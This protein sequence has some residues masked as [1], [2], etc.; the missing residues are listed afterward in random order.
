M[1][2][3]TIDYSPGIR[4]FIPLLYV[5]WADGLLSP[6]EVKLIDQQINSLDELSQSEKEILR[7]WIDPADWPDSQ[8]FKIWVQLM[9]ESARESETEILKSIA[10]LGKVMAERAAIEGRSAWQGGKTYQA[11]KFL[12]EELGV[13]GV[14]KFRAIQPKPSDGTGKSAANA[15]AIQDWLDGPA[16]DVKGR[17]K[18]VLSD[19][20]FSYEE[21]L[22][23]EAY[24]DRALLWLKLLGEQGYGSLGFPQ[25][26]GGKDD[27]MEYAAVF[28]VL[29]YHDLSLAVKFGVQFGLFGGSIFNLGTKIHHEKYLQKIGTVELPGCFAMTETGHGSNVRDLETTGLYDPDKGEIEVHS[30]TYSA[31]KEYIGNALHGKMATVFLQLIVQGENHGVHA[32][33]VPIRNDSGDLLPGIRVE[34]NGRKLG[35]NG[36]DNGRIWFEHVRVPREN[37]LNRFGQ[38]T[39]L[40][41]YES[42]IPNPSK[43]FFTMLG[44][45]VAGRLCVAMG[46]L[47]A[48]KSA[49]T[50]AVRYALARRQFKP[51]NKSVETLIMDYP[52]HQRR[53]MP[54]LVEAIALHLALSDLIQVYSQKGRQNNRDIEAM[55][56]GLKARSTWFA[57]DAIQECREACG[58]KGYLWENRF[59]DLKADSDIFTTF[60]GDNTVLLQLVAKSLLSNF[61]E[62]F[63]DA[64][65][66]GIIRYL[67]TRVSDR[68][69]QLNPVYKRKTDA[70]HLRDPRFHLHAA[71]YRERKLLHTLGSRI[72]QMFR[73]RIT[74]YDVFLRTQNHMIILAQ[75]Y[76]DRL[77]LEKFQSKLDSLE[78]PVSRKVMEKVY[79]LFALHQIS[80]H[81]DWYLEQDYFEGVK[82]KAIRR[83]VERLCAD[84]REDASILVSSFG[85]PD[86]LLS[87]PIAFGR[88]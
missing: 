33:L 66:F 62:D 86:G 74:P 44:T 83:H 47:S 68:I 21:H 15:R 19:P 41:R 71:S 50:I 48:A 61:K 31:G 73:K 43:R 6:S 30:P 3:N 23:K 12:E 8:V 5:A 57:T 18:K 51:D 11:L 81:H 13:P 36:V 85:I 27:I 38:I 24:R 72:R 53:L 63:N 29:S 75:A 39:L 1:Q 87:A 88:M 26:Y 49:I 52:S 4:S 28:E 67:G 45:L 64:G 46:A 37:L 82:T 34:D 9:R 20:V 35:L 2:P 84:V 56:A 10:A 32:V 54:K 55:A 79:Q 42:E 70:D 16:G 7:G 80:N 58:G 69:L 59:A 78:D 76:V 65:I 22:S 17:V 14:L 60:E 77:I 25:E 40:G